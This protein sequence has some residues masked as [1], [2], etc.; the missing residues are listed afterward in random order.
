MASVEKIKL[1]DTTGTA[2]DP[3]ISPL[4]VVLA[5]LADRLDFGLITDNAKKLK[6]NLVDSGALATVTT[7]ASVTNT[8]RQGDL[9]IQ[10]VNEAL[11]DLSFSYGITRNLSFT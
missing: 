4:Q 5:F 8:V 2:V 1:A 6:V 3:A 9:Q 7:V 10:R 11:L